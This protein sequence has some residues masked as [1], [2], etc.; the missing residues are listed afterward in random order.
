MLEGLLL[1]NKYGSVTYVGDGG[2]DYCPCTKIGP[3]DTILARAS[4]SGKA[5][6]FWVT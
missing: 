6:L 4:Y 2:G 1:G 3:M 5:I